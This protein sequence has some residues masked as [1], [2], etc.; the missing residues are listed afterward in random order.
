[1]VVFLILLGMIGLY[2]GL[3]RAWQLY[4]QKSAQL[5]SPKGILSLFGVGKPPA[6][7]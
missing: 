4:Q 6:L 5:S 7:P 2:Y 3:W 1:M